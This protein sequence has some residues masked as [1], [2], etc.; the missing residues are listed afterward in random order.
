M[1]A[2]KL[3]R[4]QEQLRPFLLLPSYMYG[5]IVNIKHELYN[6]RILKTQHYSNAKIISVGNIAVGGV[7]KTPVV[8]EIAK[9]LSM[10]GKTCIITGNYPFKDKRVQIVSLEGN[11][12]KGVDS[13][14]DE[15]FMM[16][17]KL[18]VSVIASKSRKAAIELAIGLGMEYMIL[19]DA[20]HHREIKKDLEICV[21]DKQKPFENGYYLPAGSIR[22]AKSSLNRCDFIL[23]VNKTGYDKKSIDCLEAELKIAGIFDKF[24]KPIKPKSVYAFCGIGKPEAFLKTL[25]DFGVDIKGYRFFNDHHIY[26]RQ[27]IELLY[28]AQKE[29]N[30]EI[31]V[32]TYKD[33]VKLENEDISYLDIELEIEKIDEIVKR[34][35]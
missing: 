9:K 24:S 3:K 23:C 4:L 29:S 8:I 26:T 17:T 27:D 19:D 22:D 1:D 16:A 12:F 21:V 18:D 11:I 5:L 28:R 32:T 20:L 13:V 10:H 31:L 15:A 2:E 6:K 25:Q 33:F 34:I 14:S 35:I 7:G 30:A